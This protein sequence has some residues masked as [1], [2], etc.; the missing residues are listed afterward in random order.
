MIVLNKLTFL[1]L[2]AGEALHK[3]GGMGAGLCMSGHARGGPDLSGA[4]WM[5]QTRNRQKPVGSPR[6]LNLYRSAASTISLALRRASP[7]ERMDMW[8]SSY[9][10]TLAASLT[11]SGRNSLATLTVPS[12]SAGI[13]AE[14]LAR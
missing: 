14:R 4:G 11:A 13:I 10:C 8:V 6:F 7:A 1:T 12:F 5:Y 3:E 9:P 2:S